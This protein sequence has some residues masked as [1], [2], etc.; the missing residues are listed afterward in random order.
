MG[1][2]SEWLGREKGRWFVGCLAGWRIGKAERGPG[3]RPYDLATMCRAVSSK[4]KDH[5]VLY[6]K[7]PMIHQNNPSP[8][9]TTPCFLKPQRI[10]ATYT[11]SD[12]V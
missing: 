12:N 1:W 5:F 2:V 7:I 6:S 4:W 9:T 3:F 8:A 11:Q 10:L